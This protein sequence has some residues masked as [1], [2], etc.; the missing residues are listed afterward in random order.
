MYIKNHARCVSYPCGNDRVKHKQPKI[1]LSKESDTSYRLYC[2]R[3]VYLQNEM[4]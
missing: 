1:K 3:F 4:T 2:G